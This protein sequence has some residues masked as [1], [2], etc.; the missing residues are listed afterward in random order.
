MSI[1][2]RVCHTTEPNNVWRYVTMCGWCLRMRL[3]LFRRAASIYVY[4]QHILYMYV[5][6]NKN[7][8][9]GN[10]DGETKWTEKAKRRKRRERIDVSDWKNE[11]ED[12]TAEALPYS[13]PCCVLCLV[14]H[15]MYLNGCRASFTNTQTASVL[16]HLFIFSLPLSPSLAL[17]TYTTYIYMFS[18]FV[19]FSSK[20]R[21]ATY[22]R[23]RSQ[24]HHYST[25]DFYI[26][27][28]ENPRRT[29]EKTTQITQN[30]M[31]KTFLLIPAH[32]VEEQMKR[33]NE[34]KTDVPTIHSRTYI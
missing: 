27:F 2:S 21:S 14:R 28:T 20:I 17:Y 1:C 34:Q 7:Y 25:C 31:E 30:K 15:S 9:Y 13:V 33:R 29:K 11:I 12:E 10:G 26:S 22:E 32:S 6:M 5:N 16:L 19:F 4:T 24:K 3:R 8:M 23:N 18:L